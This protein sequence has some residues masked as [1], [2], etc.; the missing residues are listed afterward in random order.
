MSPHPLIFAPLACLL[1]LCGHAFAEKIILGESGTLHGKIES[2][3]A[4][5]FISLRSPIAEEP[6]QVKLDSISKII[7]SEKKDNISFTNL[8]I[9]KNGDQLPAKIVGY[10]DQKLEISSSWE[11]KHSI[12]KGN[13][14]SILLKQSD[15]TIYTGPKET[16]WK[17]I[18]NCKFENGIMV[19]K[20]AGSTQWE[21]PELPT[22][23]KISWLITSSDYAT[24]EMVIASPSA[25]SKDQCYR[26]SIDSSGLKLMRQS[27]TM[28]APIMLSESP[29]FRTND[30]NEK[31]FLIELSIDRGNRTLGLSVN[32]KKIR[33]NISDPTDSGKIPDGKFYKITCSGRSGANCQLR[34]FRVAE[35]DPVLSTAHNEKKFSTKND[36]IYDLECNRYSGDLLEIQ[37]GT[38]PTI[39]FSNPHAAENIKANI[40]EV[41]KIYFAGEASTTKGKFQILTSDEG[42]LHVNTLQFQDN[43]VITEHDSLGRLLIPLSLILEINRP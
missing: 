28:R 25:S 10:K 9:F 4:K 33:D 6:L 20:G 32:R 16:G 8:I 30:A 34:E 27:P 29:E 41:A 38:E 1:G 21:A 11:S 18:Q 37:S 40:S 15:K 7:L 19:F 5:G 24:F 23:H 13:L 14:D 36:S 35:F 12:S 43:N 2:T 26:I 31:N 17:N 39:V 42:R 22:R 3:S